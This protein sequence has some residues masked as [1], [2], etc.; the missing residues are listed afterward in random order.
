MRT[1]HRITTYRHT[2]RID[3]DDAHRRHWY[4]LTPNERLT[5]IRQMLRSGVSV[6][7]VAKATDLSVHFVRNLVAD[8]PR[9]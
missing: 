2:V 6:Y 5:A 9:V 1:I 8:E 7:T 4:A 3:I